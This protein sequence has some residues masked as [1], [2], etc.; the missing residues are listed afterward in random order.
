M[1]NLGS[2]N[3]PIEGESFGLPSGFSI[4]EENGDLVIRDTDGTVAMRRADGTWELESDLALNENDISGVGAFDSESVNT[5]VLNNAG[6][7]GAEAGTVPTKNSDD[8]LSMQE[9]TDEIKTDLLVTGDRITAGSSV[10]VTE[11]VGNYDY[12]E[13]VF[14]TAVTDNDAII[15]VRLNGD[16]DGNGDYAFTSESAGERNNEFNM[17]EWRLYQA[18]MTGADVSGRYTISDGSRRAG[19]HG[20]CTVRSNDDLVATRGLR[21]AT[22]NVSEIEVMAINGDIAL[23]SDPEYHLTIRG[24][25]GTPN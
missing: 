9:T 16:A 10:S 21:D 6:L 11:D 15:A 20:N 22:E 14:N 5:E 2:D 25:L 19:F 18:T 1:A 4:D 17:S 12:Y 8:T 13:V 3:T 24:G 7:T 23:D